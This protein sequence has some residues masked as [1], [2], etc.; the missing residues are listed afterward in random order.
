MQVLSD[1]DMLECKDGGGLI[2]TNYDA[3][4]VG[5]HPEI[6]KGEHISFVD[7]P[8]YYRDGSVEWRHFEPAPKSARSKAPDH[9]L[10][11]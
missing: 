5:S 4:L 7:G 11:E 3:S 10:E 2:D 8:V 1:D 6:T 9:A